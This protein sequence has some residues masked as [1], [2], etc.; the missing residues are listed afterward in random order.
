[1]VS[2]HFHDFPGMCNIGHFTHRLF[3]YNV[4]VLGKKKTREI[5]MRRPTSIHPSI[6][7]FLVSLFSPQQV[8]FSCLLLYP[9]ITCFCV[10]A[11]HLFLFFHLHGWREEG[12]KKKW[13]R[14]GGNSSES[15]KSVWRW[16]P[17]LVLPPFS[18]S[19]SLSLL[20]RRR[21]NN[22]IAQKLDLVGGEE[23]KRKEKL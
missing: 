4:L 7:V 22:L 5:G 20:W 10:S 6:Q 2:E 18:S 14:K 8:I 23:G 19:L 11:L 13:R 1:M 15:V 16:E 21:R 12:R 17:R 3:N 9:P